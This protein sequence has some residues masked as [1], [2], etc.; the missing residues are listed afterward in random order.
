MK[1][2]QLLLIFQ[3]LIFSS[4]SQQTWNIEAGMYYYEP[5]DL[6]INQGDIV[7]WTNAGG[8]HDVNGLTNSL[9]GNSF[10]NPESF[11]SEMSCETGEEI[12]T[13]T[14][15]T[16]G[17][18][19][20]DC[21]YYGH[22]SLGM[23]ANITV[24][25]LGCEDDDAAATELAA[26]WNPNINGCE[27]A[28]E[29]FISVGYPCD[30]DLSVLGM[31]GTIADICECSCSDGCEDDDAIIESA[32]STLSTCQETV[33]YLVANYGYSEYSAC[34]WDGDMGSGSLFGGLMMYD[35][36]ECTCADIEE[37]IQTTV[38]DIIVESD[39]HNTLESAVIA[40]DLVDVLSSEGPFTVFAPTDAAFDELPEGTLDAVLADMDLLTAIL[41][42]HVSS[43]SVLSTDLVNEMMI[44][45]LNGTEL[46]V[47]IDDDGVMIDNAMVTVADVMADN[48]V[49]H[50]IDTVL[51]P[52]DGCED[53]N[54]MIEQYFGNFFISECGA[55]I[56]YL[57]ANYSYSQEE[58]CAWNGAP[59]LDL[60]GLIISDICECVCSLENVFINEN[61]IIKEPLYIID[62]LG[63]VVSTP[64]YDKPL[65]IIFNDGSVQ[66]IMITN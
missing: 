7:I 16:A 9:T 39:S 65:F 32:F 31:S 43:G 50:V 37:P 57:E 62:L 42:H 38:V 64:I 63:Q 21:S 18:Y 35:F 51:I 60:N 23:V 44:T 15:N 22:A 11:S 58:A 12:F 3:F 10:N 2:I 27:D 30:T 66:K 59:M 28:V 29:Y 6:V 45:T 33:D 8:C 20:Y 46:M 40:A 13:Y 1:A 54:T 47:S 55:L 14:F 25:E 19:N 26:F 52:E 17:V 49:V 53:D 5:S 41:T 48:G 24:N 61:N 34:Q 36:C 56:S 4:Y